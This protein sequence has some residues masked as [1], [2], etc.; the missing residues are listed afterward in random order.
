MRIGHILSQRNVNDS[1][2]N[3]S[4]GQSSNNTYSEWLAKSIQEGF[5][6]HYSEDES[7][8]VHFSV[9]VDTVSYTKP[10]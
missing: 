2:Q 5:I 8:I 4:Q 7:W 3:M 1:P 9:M 6:K 10:G